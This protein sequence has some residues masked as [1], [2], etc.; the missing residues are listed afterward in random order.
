MDLQLPAPYTRAMALSRAFFNANIAAHVVKRGSGDVRIWQK[1]ALDEV[2]KLL[3]A[4]Q[5]PDKDCHYQTQID[6]ELFGGKILEWAV[7]VRSSIEELL[8]AAIS[9]RASTWP[10][11]S[12]NI[13]EFFRIG[14]AGFRTIGS[15]VIS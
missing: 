7:E 8:E 9:I 5:N 14:G 3:K 10:E 1:Q 2:I 13:N 15:E 11:N 6:I 12:S 4:L